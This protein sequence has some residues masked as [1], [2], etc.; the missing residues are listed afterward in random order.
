MLKNGNVYVYWI[1]QP[2]DILWYLNFC[3][4]LRKYYHSFLHSKTKWNKSKKN[5][6]KKKKKSLKIRFL[7]GGAFGLL[8]KTK[9]NVSVQWKI[10]SSGIAQLTLRTVFSSEINYK[11]L[12][13]VDEYSYFWHFNLFDTKELKLAVHPKQT[14]QLFPANFTFVVWYF[15]LIV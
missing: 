3:N 7:D 5:S 9:G 1:V 10:N 13:N 4:D 14:K 12:K 15:D 2:W 8:L 6:I 11:K